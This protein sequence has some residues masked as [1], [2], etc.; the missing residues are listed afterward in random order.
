MT[1]FPKPGLFVFCERIKE[2]AVY[3][4]K[5]HEDALRG[6]FTNRHGRTDVPWPDIPMDFEDW[7]PNK[8]GERLDD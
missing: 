8:K 3:W 5:W 6:C 1:N 4:E 2:E 7:E